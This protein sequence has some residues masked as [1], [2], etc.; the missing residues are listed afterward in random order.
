M[1]IGYDRHKKAKTMMEGFSKIITLKETAKYLKKW[2]LPGGI[3]IYKMAR[4]I[5]THVSKANIKSIKRP[6][7]T[8]LKMNKYDCIQRYI[9]T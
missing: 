1:M 5:Y 8:F 7:C 6:L 3:I 9:H 2:S 4:E